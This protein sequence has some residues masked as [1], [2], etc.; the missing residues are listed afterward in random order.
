MPEIE[1]LMDAAPH[2][3]E[4]ERLDVLVALAGAYER[5]QSPLDLPDPVE[6]I[7]FRRDQAGLF[8]ED[9]EPMIG[10]RRRAGMSTQERMA[11]RKRLE[12][13]PVPVCRC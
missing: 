7:K 9:L 10:R 6:A 11:G 13:C 2:T 8:P 5:K 4:G 3:A 1:T 12:R